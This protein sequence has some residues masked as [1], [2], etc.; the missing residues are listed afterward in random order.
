MDLKDFI[1]DTLVQITE[2]VK[3][4]QDI[5]RDMGGLVN[6]MLQVGVC[7]GETFRFKDSDYPATTVNF[8]VG[9]EESNSNGNKTGIGVFLGKASLGKEY[10]KGNE[11]QSI[12][13][14]EFSVT[15]V[16]PYISREG[17][18]VNISDVFSH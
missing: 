10:N 15:V 1:R 8:K 2:G 5:C 4:A 6:P 11:I 16:F 7:N 3:E 18:H 14:V 12:T 17:K 9:L 13:N